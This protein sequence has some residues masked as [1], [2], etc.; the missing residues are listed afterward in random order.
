MQVSPQHMDLCADDTKLTMP[1]NNRMSFPEKLQDNIAAE[2]VSFSC[3]TS[4]APS[5]RSW[6][7]SSHHSLPE[8]YT[9]DPEGSPWSRALR[10]PS[11]T[12]RNTS[13]PQSAMHPMLSPEDHISRAEGTWSTAY[14]HPLPLNPSAISQVKATLS[15]QPAPK[16]EMSL[17]AGQWEKRKLIGSGTFGDVYEATNRHTGA[18]CAVKA[19][20]IIPND[21]RSAESLKQLDQEIKLLSQF[22]HENIV[23]YYGSETIEGHLYIYMEYVHP[24]SVNKYIQQHCGAITE[25]IVRNFTRHILRGLAFLHDQNIMHR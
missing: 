25:S 17:V 14:F 5:S 21:S 18:L 16:V 1:S 9:W 4:S 23:Q 12:P 19:I 8:T 22:K 20:S 2:A 7:P 13:V 3:T 24:G 15:N 11:L 6:S 10:S